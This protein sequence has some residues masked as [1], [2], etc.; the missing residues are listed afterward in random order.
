MPSE[1]CT[2]SMLVLLAVGI[3]MSS[4]F[5]T[6]IMLVLL[7]VGIIMPSEFCTVSM[8]VLLAVGN[9]KETFENVYNNKIYVTN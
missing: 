4:E 5:C 8:L 1:F 9:Y 6:D 3:I 2:D 7:A